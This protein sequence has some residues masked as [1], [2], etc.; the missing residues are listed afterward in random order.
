MPLLIAYLL[1]V[2]EWCVAGLGGPPLY[3]LV[4][5]RVYLLSLSSRW[6]TRASWSVFEPE[7]WCVDL[8]LLLLGEVLLLSVLL[9]RPFWLVDV[10]LMSSSVQS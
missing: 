3:C 9:G 2:R 5:V 6:R 10:A 8:G 7:P 4:H 1:V